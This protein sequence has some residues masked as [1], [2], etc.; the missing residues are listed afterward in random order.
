MIIEN[1][2]L[3]GKLILFLFEKVVNKIECVS[4]D[5]HTPVT[6][7]NVDVVDVCFCIAII[8]VIGFVKFCDFIFCL[9]LQN[10]KRFI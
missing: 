10:S 3:R 2:I 9:L 8:F 5:L 4:A 7:I 6:K 1:Y